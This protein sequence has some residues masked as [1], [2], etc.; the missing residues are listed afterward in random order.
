[1]AGGETSQLNLDQAHA[2][3]VVSPTEETLR[4]LMDSARG[5]IFH[6]ARMYSRDHPDEDMVQAGYEGLIK[7]LKRYDPD[8]GASFTTYASHLIRGE[9]RHYLR[10]ESSY[11]RPG[12]LVD[13]Q[14]RVERFIDERLVVTG[15]PPDA[16]T[17][18]E[19]L[20]VREEGVVEVLRAGLVPL[21]SVDLSKVRSLRYE[22]FRLPLEDRITLHNAISK[23]SEVQRRVVD[24]LF[25]RDMT[26][27]EAADELGT[28]QRQ[29]SRL[30]HRSLAT[31]HD[32]LE[33]ND[34]S[35]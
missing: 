2:V 18:A 28:S 5:L 10:R 26:Q 6:F 20:N 34:S 25:Y 23:L 7:A 16:A 9:I 13:L 24:L 1:M 27:Q 30:L 15:E 3:Y 32:A 35:K 29:V 22:S 12:C 11:Y 17:I 21:D 4:G 31:L 8:R 33:G 14:S 19:A